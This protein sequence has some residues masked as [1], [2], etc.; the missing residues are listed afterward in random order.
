MQRIPMPAAIHASTV[1][2][3]FVVSVLVQRCMMR[4]LLDL[5]VIN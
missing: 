4:E 2:G 1:L 3:D 5:C